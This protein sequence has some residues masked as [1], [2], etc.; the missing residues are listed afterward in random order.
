MMDSSCMLDLVLLGF[1]TMRYSLMVVVM[2]GLAGSTWC[3]GSSVSPDS[4]DVAIQRSVAYFQA[5]PA[6]L[7]NDLYLLYHFLHRKFGLPL[8]MTK[9]DFLLEAKADPERFQFLQPYLRILEKTAFR[10]SYLNEQGTLDDLTLAGIWYDRLRPRKLLE[11]RIAGMDFMDDYQV[12]HAY[13]AICI[14]RQDFHAHV[15]SALHKR[16]L[17]RMMEI[18]QPHDWFA[19][20]NIEAVAL[21]HFGG[22]AGGLQKPVIG[23]ILAQQK[24]DGLW[25]DVPGENRREAVHTTMLALWAL[26][27]YRHPGAED[28][29]FIV[30]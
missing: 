27:E 22:D 23:R 1:C 25:E 8:P 4:L 26:L 12:T 20:I 11:S 6:S 24:G 13:L 14:L 2:M 30:R 18:A 10:R 19:D 7:S 21:L 17:A 29:G 5:H 3:Q 16:V 9:D 15:D 28:V